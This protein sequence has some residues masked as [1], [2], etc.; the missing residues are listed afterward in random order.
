MTKKVRELITTSGGEI[1]GEEYRS[2]G[3][4]RR[5]P[6]QREMAQIACESFTAATVVFLGL[7][8]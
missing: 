1:V 6:E 8:I 3:I 5:R 4:S 7:R 2:H